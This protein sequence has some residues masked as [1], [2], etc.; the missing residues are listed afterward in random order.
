MRQYA[1]FLPAIR[2]DLGELL[3]L[4]VSHEVDS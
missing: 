4:D 2:V 3:A 1:E